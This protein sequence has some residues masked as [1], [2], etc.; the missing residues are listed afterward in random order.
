MFVRVLVR[1]RLHALDGGVR[2][3][4][5]IRMDKLEIKSQRPAARGVHRIDAVDPSEALVRIDTIIDQIAVPDSDHAGR[6]ERPRKAI[7]IGLRR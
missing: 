7:R 5:I 2:C 4:E 3:S 1:T 6:L